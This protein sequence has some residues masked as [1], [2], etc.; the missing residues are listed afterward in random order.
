MNNTMQ[1]LARGLD[2]AMMR[3][4]AIN[5]NIANINTPGYKRRDINF[6]E[7]LSRELQEKEG[8]TPLRTTHRGH[9]PGVGFSRDSFNT[10]RLSEF[11]Y[12]NDGGSVDVDTEMANLAKN[13]IYYT[14]LVGQ[15]STRFSM[16]NTVIERGGN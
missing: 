11:S 1:L 14:S 8:R 6:E 13:N 15:L 2:G 10:E 9:S 4:Q 7:V 5:N 3:Q 16:L 12:K